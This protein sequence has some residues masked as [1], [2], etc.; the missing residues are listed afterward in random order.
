MVTRREMAWL[1]DEEAEC[2]VEA[3]C[4]IGAGTM[5]PLDSV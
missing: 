5:V 3:E 4:D 1:L 2:G